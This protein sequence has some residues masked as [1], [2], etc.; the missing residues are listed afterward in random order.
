MVAD[1]G[2]SIFQVWVI[3]LL[4]VG[5]HGFLAEI[6]DQAAGLEQRVRERTAELSNS[7]LK[8]AFQAEQLRELAPELTLVEQRERTHLAE[9]IHNGLQ[10]LLVAAKLRVSPLGR[11]QA[12]EVRAACGD[13]NQLLD[14]ALADARSLT[15]ELSPPI[16]RTGGLLAGLEWLARWSQDTHHLTVRV[17]VPAI[18]LPPLPEDLTVLL[19]QSVRELLFNIVKCARVSEVQVALSLTEQHLTI[20]VT[21]AGGGFDPGSLR[22]EGGV[23]GGFGLAR[24]RHRIEL[25]GGCLDVVSAPG[26]GSRITLVAPLPAAAPPPCGRN[27]SRRAAPDRP[28]SRGRPSIRG[29]S[30]S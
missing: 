11:V 9:R 18:A 8:G 16:L 12:P 22:G 5:V 30:A 29:G 28:R 25:L 17:Q 20:L 27:P 19:F 3:A 4:V 24:I 2:L 7:L 1:H 6:Q 10:Q 14:D 26:Q 23:S 13:I 15:A 21:E